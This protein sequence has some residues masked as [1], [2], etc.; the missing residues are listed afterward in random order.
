M[1]SG[2]RG[3]QLLSSDFWIPSSLCH[4]APDDIRHR[5]TPGARTAGRGG[6]DELGREADAESRWQLHRRHGIARVSGTGHAR[7]AVRCRGPGAFHRGR[8]GDVLHH[9]LLREVSTRADPAVGG[10]RRRAARP[11]GR[12]VADGDG[13]GATPRSHHGAR[14]RGPTPGQRSTTGP[15]RRPAIVRVHGGR[16]PR[17]SGPQ[18]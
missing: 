18:S 9:R 14:P 6:H 8:A 11:A 10:R 4:Y 3:S 2:C 16:P 7:R 15:S 1:V 5:H 12:V 17:S 13:E